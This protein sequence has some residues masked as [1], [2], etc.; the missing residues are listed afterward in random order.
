M[1]SKTKIVVLRM[2]ELI[3]T[4]IFVGLGILLI[5][6]L[7][8]MFSSK[9][10]KQKDSAAPT[11]YIPGVYSA[12]LVLNGQNIDVSVTVDSDRINSINFVQLDE[13]VTTMYPLM[14]PALNELT[15]QIIDSQSTANIQL[16]E[17]MKYTQS[18]LVSTI[19]EALSKA[20]P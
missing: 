3:Y 19:E 14:E 9:G 8:Y 18:A 16:D 20:A 7:V 5:I 10:G 4:A 11:S 6:L 15:E 12:S 1:S 13:A 17:G 2:K